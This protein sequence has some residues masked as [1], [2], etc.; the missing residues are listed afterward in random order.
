VGRSLANK[1]TIT[2]FPSRHS[3]SNEGCTLTGPTVEETIEFDAFD[4]LDP[5]DDSRNIAWNFEG[6]PTTLREKR[7]L[8]LYMK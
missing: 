7:W 3:N 1:A 5:F 6:E 8:E 2:P 4:L